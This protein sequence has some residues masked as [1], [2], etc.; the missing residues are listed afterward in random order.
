MEGK[1]EFMN[2]FEMNDFEKKDL[3]N[4]EK[5]LRIDSILSRKQLEIDA[6]IQAT[7]ESTNTSPQDVI[8]RKKEILAAK[9]KAQGKN[10]K[11]LSQEEKAIL[12]A[13]VEKEYQ[14]L[15]EQEIVKKQK[16]ILSS[17]LQQ[18]EENTKQLLEDRK[19]LL[20]SVEKEYQKMVREERDATIARYHKSKQIVAELNQAAKANPV[21]KT[22]A[23]K[24]TSTTKDRTATKPISKEQQARRKLE[25]IEREKF[26]AASQQVAR[27]KLHFNAL[28]NREKRKERLEQQNHD[29]VTQPKGVNPVEPTKKPVSSISKKNANV[30]PSMASSTFL[31]APKKS[32]SPSRMF[33]GVNV[34][35]QIMDFYHN[36]QI[37]SRF[38]AVV[39]GSIKDTKKSFAKSIQSSIDHKKARENAK[40]QKP[41][42]EPRTL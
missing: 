5:E 11:Q 19:K 30:E 28:W 14:K 23:L 20:A 42:F 35:Q 39:G 37:G 17:K 7:K 10:G 15:V 40:R 9:L 4:T 25:A 24:D 18:Q 8:K 1:I 29:T 36:S 2:D 6:L 12:R 33:K 31:R 16:G 32:F 27:K 21:S 13:S 26:R 3:D 38:N 34:Y 41:R 22:G